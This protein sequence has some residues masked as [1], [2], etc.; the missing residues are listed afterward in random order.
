MAEGKYVKI[1]GAIK[2]VVGEYTKIGGVIKEIT[3]NAIKIGGDIKSIALADRFFYTGESV[4]GELYCVSNQGVEE[5]HYDAADPIVVAVNGN[6]E[7]YWAVGSTVYKIKVDGTLG[8][9]Y[10]GHTT[11]IK[12]IALENRAGITYVYT[13]DFGGTV[14]CLIDGGTSAG[15]I[16]SGVVGTNHAIYALAVDK[17]ADQ[18]IIGTGWEADAIWRTALG[19]ATFSRKYISSADITALAVDMDSRV[20][21][22]D[23]AGNYRQLSLD[24]YVY[25]TKTRTG[26][27]SQIQIGHDGIGYCSVVSEK[28]ILKW[29]RATGVTT[30]EYTPSPVTDAY[31]YGV[32]VDKGGNVYGLYRNDS[33]Q[34]GNLI[35]KISKTG[36]YVWDWQSYVNVK[37]YGLAVTPG[38]KAAGFE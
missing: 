6:G 35:Y 13:G 29:P 38:L 2:Q 11:T 19:E 26:G 25:W 17:A 33:A 12:S 34:S 36:S 5:W 30:W 31:A 14:K 23:N 7:S 20:Y 9:T 24:G 15:V 10:T 16:W 27:I 8:W 3:T 4:N 21:S 22:G 28:K 37:F 18:L 32:G 1:D